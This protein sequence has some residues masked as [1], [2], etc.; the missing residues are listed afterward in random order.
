[1]G[2]Y[3]ADFI[4]IRNI[5]LGYTFNNKMLGKSGISNLKAYFQLANPGMLFSKIKYL[6][7]DVVGPT[8]NRG[9]TL[10]INASF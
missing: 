3:K 4:K 7:M 6:D 9:F 5:N 8:W 1:L 2:Y 10:G